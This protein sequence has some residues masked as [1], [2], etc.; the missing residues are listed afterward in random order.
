MLKLQT[1][2]EDWSLKPQTWSLSSS[3]CE[4]KALIS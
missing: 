3:I 4:L 2:G 1:V